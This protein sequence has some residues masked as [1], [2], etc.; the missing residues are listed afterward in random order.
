MMKKST[1]CAL[2]C[3]LLLPLACAHAADGGLPNA[4]AQAVKAAKPSHMEKAIEHLNKAK[5]M[6]GLLQPSAK[7]DRDTISQINKAKANLEEAGDNKGEHRVKAIEL[8]KEAIK[9]GNASNAGKLVDQAM[10]ETKQ[11]IAFAADLAAKKAAEKAIPP[12]QKHMMAAVESLEKAKALITTAKP[13][14]KPDKDTIAQFHKAKT[15]LEKAEHNKGGHREKAIELVKQAIKASTSDAAA[16][17]A[18]QA[19][20]ETNAGIDFAQKHMM[21]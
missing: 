5:A 2:F 8:L 7:L 3:S 6:L 4:A 16:K 13:G 9:A 11:G 14:S 15:S 12:V 21:K 10:D 17:L 18:D 19:I 1:I 20:A